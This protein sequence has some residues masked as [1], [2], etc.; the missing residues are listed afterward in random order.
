[1]IPWIVYTATLTIVKWLYFTDVIPILEDLMIWC[2]AGVW[3]LETQPQKL[4][5]YR[6]QRSWGKVMF[7]H[8]SVILFTGGGSAPLHAGIHTPWDQRQA[9]PQSWHPPGP[10]AGT[11]PRVDTP[12]DQ[13]QAPPSTVHAGRYGQQVRG[14]HPTGM[15][16]CLQI[17]F[18]SFN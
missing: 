4:Y 14:T 7:L 13:R 1:M 6:P 2:T 16:S 3:I 15:Q 18:K 8:V 5:I 12:Q 11:P 17:R 10:E 9:P